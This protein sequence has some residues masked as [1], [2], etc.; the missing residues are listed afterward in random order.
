MLL[1]TAYIVF[2]ATDAG[3]PNN[4]QDLKDFSEEQ[5]VVYL[6]WE[7]QGTHE[8]LQNIKTV[9]RS[10]RKQHTVLSLHPPQNHLT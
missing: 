7:K 6:L 5:W 9:F 4:V 10:T 8:Q 3:K 2:Y 1:G